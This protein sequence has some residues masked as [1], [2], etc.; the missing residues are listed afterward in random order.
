MLLRLNQVTLDKGYLNSVLS[1]FIGNGNLFQRVK[2][3]ARI[4]WWLMSVIREFGGLEKIENWSYIVTSSQKP[5][6]RV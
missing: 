3:A 1:F 2:S 6:L 5:E 4:G